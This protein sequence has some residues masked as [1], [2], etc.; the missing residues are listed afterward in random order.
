MLRW[1][2]RCF[3]GI[4]TLL[5]LVL[6]AFAFGDIETLRHVPFF[7]SKGHTEENEPPARYGV[8]PLKLKFSQKIFI[9]YFL[10]THVDTFFFALRLFFSSMLVTRKIKST[11]QKRDNPLPQSSSELDLFSARENDVQRS[12]LRSGIA[13]PKPSDLLQGAEVIH[14]IIIPNYGEEIETLRTTLA[15]LASHPRAVSQYEV[16][17]KFRM[18]APLSFI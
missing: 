15:V 11:L 6:L 3:P 16:S 14:S 7:H 17:Q 5:L 2:S 1:L 18:L 12:R 8:A 4:S 9:F 10:L 13:T